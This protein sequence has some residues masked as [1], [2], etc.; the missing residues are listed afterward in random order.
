[1]WI[2][3]LRGRFQTEL[4]T[5]SF[6]TEG[7]LKVLV[8]GFH[9]GTVREWFGECGPERIQTLMQPFD[10]KSPAAAALPHTDIRCTDGEEIGASGRGPSVHCKGTSKGMAVL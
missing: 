1:M 7:Q 10:A 2:V 6:L 9:W 5:R 3:L 4:H 8:N